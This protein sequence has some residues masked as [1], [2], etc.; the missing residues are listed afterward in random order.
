MCDVTWCLSVQT[1][2]RQTP[3]LVEIFGRPKKV[4]LTP[5][6]IELAKRLREHALESGRM[7]PKESTE[8]PQTIPPSGSLVDCASGD[9]DQEMNEIVDP[10]ATERIR[11]CCWRRALRDRVRVRR[12]T[13]HH[14]HVAIRETTMALLP[15]TDPR[16]SFDDE[17]EVCAQ[18]RK[19]AKSLTVVL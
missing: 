18:D 17:F 11:S 15:Y 1:L 3:P 4:T 10:A 19:T 13:F 14:E 16:A 8:E 12:K 5:S 6:G 9:F 7:K 2:L